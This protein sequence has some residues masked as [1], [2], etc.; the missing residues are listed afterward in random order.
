MS[1]VGFTRL[2]PL[3]PLLF[4]TFINDL[5]AGLEGILSNV[6]DGTK[7]EELLTS[8][9]LGRTCIVLDTSEDWKVASMKLNKGKCWILHLE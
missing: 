4:N 1:P 9:K 7:L 2:H 3:S 6:T 5:D 8:S